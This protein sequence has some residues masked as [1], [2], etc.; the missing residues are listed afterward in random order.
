MQYIYLNYYPG[1]GEEEGYARRGCKVMPF[2]FETTSCGRATKRRNFLQ[3]IYRNN[4]GMMGARKVVASMLSATVVDGLEMR[5]T[6]GG[7]G[8]QMRKKH[9]L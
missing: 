9:Y 8:R 7:G 2:F 5:A 4:N 6:L 1:L 3:K